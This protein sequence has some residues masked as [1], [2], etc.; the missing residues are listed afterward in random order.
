MTRLEFLKQQ[1]AWANGILA[2]P[3]VQ[4]QNGRMSH[5]VA[6]EVLEET[7]DELLDYLALQVLPTSIKLIHAER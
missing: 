6:N 7:E 3:C 2:A 4:Y 5:E 1:K